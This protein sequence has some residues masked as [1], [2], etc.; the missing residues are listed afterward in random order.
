MPGS[1][2]AV[3]LLSPPIADSASHD[4]ACELV[5]FTGEPYP[6]PKPTAKC[7]KWTIVEWFSED[8]DL[9]LWAELSK[10]EPPPCYARLLRIRIRFVDAM[11]SQAAG[12]LATPVARRRM[13]L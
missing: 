9:D 6:R 13:D 3:L 12:M 7:P 11:T 2:I 10:S 1:W 4:S 8:S 5:W